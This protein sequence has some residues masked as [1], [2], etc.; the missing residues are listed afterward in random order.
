M[1]SIA[2]V[3]LTL[4]TNLSGMGVLFGWQPMPND[5]EK[6]EYIVQIEPELAATL[7]EGQSI[8]ITSD[9]PDDIGPIG[10]ITIIVGN[11]QPPRRSLETR[12]KPWPEATS[13][14]KESRDGIVETQFTSPSTQ[15]AAAGRYGNTA[16]SGN[17]ILPPGGNADTSADPFNR[18]LQQGAQQVRDTVNQVKDQILPPS[19]DQLFGSSNGAS[20]GLQSAIDNTKNQFQRSMQRGVQQV[21]DRT[22][23]QIR[24]SANDVGN[25]ASDAVNNF[26]R[27]LTAE[28]SIL[29]NQRGNSQNSILPPSPDASG[30][31]QP[32]PQLSTP[33]IQQQ[34]QPPLPSSSLAVSSQ[35][36]SNPT[37]QP[38]V[39]NAPWP[40]TSGNQPPPS[41]T[42]SNT[43]PRY[44]D[45]QNQMQSPS[46]PN[47][48]Q[49]QSP[50][51]DGFDLANRQPQSTPPNY[52]NGQ[53]SQLEGPQLTGPSQ[54]ASMTPTATPTRAEI[55][56]SQQR[57]GPAI[58]REIM[59]NA[60]PVTH[61]AAGNPPQNFQQRQV[62][63]RQS[64]DTRPQDYG[65][66]RNNQSMDN[67]PA[68][69]N[70]TVFPLVLSWVL[71]GGS[72]IGNF[73]QWW[74][75]LDVR[76]KYRGV[77]HGAPVRRDRFDD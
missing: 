76:S 26:G 77:V 71:L 18:N 47:P 15:S 69:N 7:R 64:L 59:Q 10:R 50:R 37:S 27:S 57:T 62:A 28:Q 19:S 6:I 75:Y 38:G 1:E 56:A 73:F 2:L 55:S 29:S 35:E 72:V 25:A 44:G 13:V 52:G 21:A 49:R 67:P 14:T 16:G 68:Q 70:S 66:G 22:E 11:E 12:L 54:R 5:S 31:R 39:F 48:Q 45:Q 58:T 32:N 33:P 63:E 36:G 65:W 8:P 61:Q 24:Q 17:S 42:A 46:W 9:I 20:R 23:Q 60:S 43:P 51:N 53:N 34:R 4:G 41:V 30:R 3:L 40:E 74:S